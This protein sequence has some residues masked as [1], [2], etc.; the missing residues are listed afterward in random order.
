MLIIGAI[1]GALLIL[2][3]LWDVFETIVFPRRVTRRLR[4]TRLF[5]RLTWIV[6]SKAV[7]A[8]VPE[9]RHETYLSFFGP[10]SLLLLLTIWAGGLI[11][12]FACLQ[13]SA[14]SGVQ[15][16]LGE[17]P[18][19]GADLYFSGTTFFTLGLGDV[20]PRTAIAMALTVIEAGVGFGLLALVI[21]YLPALNQSFSRREINI[22]LM[23]AHAGSPPSAAEMLSRHCFA[24]SMSPLCETLAEWERWTAELLESHLSYPVL[25]YFRSQHDNQSWLGAITTI[26]D[27]SAFVL[28]NMEGLCKR[29]ARMTFAIALHAVSD[30]SIIFRQSPRGFEVDRLP[31][32]QFQYL[33]GL[34]K[35]SGLPI[36]EESEAVE[37]LAELRRMYE[38]YIY[39]LSRFLLIAVPNWLPEPG[40]I[41]NWQKSAAS[42]GPGAHF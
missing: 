2:I 13:W 24:E 17:V 5:Y 3:V 35:H 41:D 20:A 39:S 15:T 26:L 21:G 23:D 33:R 27:T 42:P 36:Q 30:L 38:P 7:R 29:Q 40:E 28:A 34:L 6:W 14:G 11:L 32:P 22:S 37:K 16:L 18:G 19:F 4:L 31:L 12:G 25:A 1:A 10:I 8:I 9:G